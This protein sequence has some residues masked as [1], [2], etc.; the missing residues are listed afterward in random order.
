MSIAFGGC[1]SPASRE[2]ST[3]RAGLT[4]RPAVADRTSNAEAGDIRSD[5]LALNKFGY[6]LIKAAM[7]AA[8]EDPFRGEG[9]MTVL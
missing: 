6:D 4:F 3:V 7:L 9:K 1:S 2:A 5:T 8:G